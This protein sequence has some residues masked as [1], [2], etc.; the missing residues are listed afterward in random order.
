MD[1]T[2][3]LDEL[4][5]APRT[6]PGDYTE[7]GVLICGKCQTPKQASKELPMPGGCT[8]TRMVPIVCKCE[9]EKQEQDR[10]EFERDQFSFRMTELREK[11]GVT[12]RAYQKFTFAKDDRREAKIS[13]ICHRYVDRWEDMKTDNIGMLFYGTVGT[14]KSFYASAIVNAL[15]YNCIPAA[16]T[17]FPRLLNIL[18]S[19]RDRQ[20]CI[21]HLQRYQLLVIDDLGVERDSS[22]AAEQVF[23]V[24]DARANSGLPLIVTTNLTLDELKGPPTMQYARIYDR[25]LELCPVHIKMT[26]ES[27]RTGNAEARKAKAREL[28]A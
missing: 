21:D 27:R 2:K 20:E 3:V 5:R 10:R 13:D 28:L 8:M 22:Y 4:A 26:G 6:D 11:Y 12:D 24:I 25:V 16:V 23:N 18:Q 1:T 9:Q 14:G 19:T 7:D 15:L 17:S